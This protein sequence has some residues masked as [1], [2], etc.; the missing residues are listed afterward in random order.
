MDVKQVP[1]S[2]DVETTREGHSALVHCLHVS[3]ITLFGIDLQT[4][5]QAAIRVPQTMVRG[6]E[7]KTE[8]GLRWERSLGY[9][10]FMSS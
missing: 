2:G 5:P 3:E 6:C 1:T 9:R 4:G 10:S 8:K 7:A